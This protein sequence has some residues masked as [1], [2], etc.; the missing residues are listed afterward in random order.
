[1]YRGLIQN[2]GFFVKQILGSV[3]KE[4]ESVQEDFIFCS[5]RRTFT[6]SPEII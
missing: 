1:M 6:V 5:A 4:A 3:E 2:V